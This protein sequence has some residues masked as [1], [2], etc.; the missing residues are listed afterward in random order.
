MK[1]TIRSGTDDPPVD[2]NDVLDELDIFT[3][4]MIEGRVEVKQGD[5]L[6]IHTGWY[7]HAQFGAETDE[8]KHIHRHLGPDF[9]IVPW[10]LKKKVHLWGADLVSTDHPKHIPIGLPEPQNW[11]LTLGAFP[12]EFQGGEAAFCRAVAFLEE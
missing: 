8:E 2:L 3:P 12:W 11:Y 5:I 4:E 7:K 6:F 10:L 1:A 9:D